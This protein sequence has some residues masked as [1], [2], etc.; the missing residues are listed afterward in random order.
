MYTY[1]VTSSSFLWSP[2]KQHGQRVFYYSA[3]PLEPFHYCSTPLQGLLRR[4]RLLWSLHMCTQHQNNVCKK[5]PPNSAALWLSIIAFIST[6]YEVKKIWC[7]C[8]VI[9]TS[10]HSCRL[11]ILAYPSYCVAN[12]PIFTGFLLDMDT[13][14]GYYKPPEHHHRE[15][16]RWWLSGLNYEY[17]SIY[18]LTFRPRRGLQL[19]SCCS[20]DSGDEQDERMLRFPFLV[21]QQQ[22]MLVSSTGLVINHQ[23]FIQCVLLVRGRARTHLHQ[24]RLNQV[25]SSSASLSCLRC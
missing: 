8:V 11:F 24:Q 5:A 1:V 9:R 20:G 2:C 7:V 23:L 12:A 4:E 13:I 6:G 16:P 19:F 18:Y 21:S 3:T 10:A 17:P 14:R 22:C 15:M 25:G